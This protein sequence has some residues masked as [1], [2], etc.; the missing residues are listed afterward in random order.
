MCAA[1]ARRCL[2]S[3][4]AACDTARAREGG[5]Q[6][7]E[8]AIH[9]RMSS[10]APP[11]RKWDSP[12]DITVDLKYLSSQQDKL[13][14]LDSLAEHLGWVAVRQLASER[15][16]NSQYSVAR[17]NSTAAP[18]PMVPPAGAP[19]TPPRRHPSQPKEAST[20]TTEVLRPARRVHLESAI[21]HLRLAVL[22]SDSKHEP[23]S[24]LD[25]QIASFLEVLTHELAHEQSRH[26]LLQSLS[27]D[28]RLALMRN[29]DPNRLPTS[30]EFQPPPPPPNR[31]STTAGRRRQNEPTACARNLFD[32]FEAA[33]PRMP[34]EPVASASQPSAIAVEE[35]PNSAD[36]EAPMVDLADSRP[37]RGAARRALRLDE[38]TD[39][40]SLA[41]LS[42]AAAPPSATSSEGFVQGFHA[43][44]KARVGPRAGIAEHY[45][46]QATYS[47]RSTTPRMASGI[48][49]QMQD[50][51]RGGNAAL[52]VEKPGPG[53]G[54]YY[55]AMERDHQGHFSLARQASS[56]FGMPLVSP[57]KAAAWIM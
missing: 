15:L 11:L 16:E 47:Y 39:G 19:M 31:H 44:W 41:E 34:E 38:Q 53:L 23:V 1:R 43:K 7:S 55:Y 57:T 40:V 3:L 12:D 50:V 21:E 28:Q 46:R 35:P 9:P 2:S 54:D 6:L 30:S 4:H 56:Y 13:V 27:P 49:T 20:P 25:G 8:P 5:A 52:N 24:R 36:N 33:A 17:T 42:R 18:N 45:Q 22:E 14:Q 48:E 29:V 51:P 37:Y 10:S 26:S 32:R